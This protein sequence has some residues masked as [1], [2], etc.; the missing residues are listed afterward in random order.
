MSAMAA[1]ARTPWVP[2][3]PRSQDTTK[4]ASRARAN[5]NPDD[6]AVRRRCA[7]EVPDAQF[8]PSA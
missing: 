1:L 6:R 4:T 7:P 8:L 5:S 2:R 3:L